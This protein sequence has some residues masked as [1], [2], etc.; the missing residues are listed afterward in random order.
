[1]QIFKG[2]I[3]TCDQVGSVFNYLVE[4][5]G[6]IAFVGDELP[7][8]FTTSP[9]VIDL[10]EMALLPAFGDG[11]IHFSNWALFNSTFDV[12][13]ASKLAEIGPM[14]KEYADRESGIK[15][16][17]GFGHSA[18]SVEE[19]RLITRAEIDIAVKKRPVY[20]VC[21]DGHS[22]VANT[23][24]IGLLPKEIRML[25]GF[26]LES[27]Q[28]FHEAFLAATDF[29]SS[30]MPPLKLAQYMLKGMDTLA[31]FGVGLVHTVEG[32]GF[33]RDL[34]VDL[35]RF[36]AKSSQLQFRVYFQTMDVDKVLKRKLPRI[37]G[38]F[39]CALDG[40]FGAKDAALLEPYADDPNNC[41][42]LFYS[43]Q[44]VTN[45]V[46]EA[47]RA[48][49]QVQLHCIGDAA[50]VQAVNAIETALEDF[51][52]VNHR[53]TLIHA[54]LI[55]EQT[56][57]RIAEL[58]II[59]TLQPGFLISPLEPPDYMEKIIGER[60]KDGSPFRKMIDLGILISGGSDGPVTAPNPIEGIYGACN[61]VIPKQSV[62]IQEAL[63]MYTYNVAYTSFDEDERGSL[64]KGKLADMVILNCNPLKLEPKE[65]LQLEVKKL[66]I[67]GLEY[68]KNSS[69]ISALL[70]SLKNRSRAV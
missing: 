39:A 50:V 19:K 63:R 28:I 64:E 67:E 17:F 60:A 10:G 48:G 35:V 40:C 66:I 3:I 20:L 59:I 18:N 22:A 36:L 21:Y 34:D 54:C 43:D 47:N 14:I 56:L 23:A 2:N 5:E 33:P 11:H 30:K 24:A 57:K 44:K 49:L 7:P 8:S 27:G 32:V 31:D 41:G 16:L 9:E 42:I 4:D 62:T 37:G 70:G 6:R 51:P 65:L 52:R 55:P 1:V 61:N 13:G 46:V 45:F 68:K 12:R 29:I 53:H 69:L 58:G 25:N 15:V 38:C 26:D